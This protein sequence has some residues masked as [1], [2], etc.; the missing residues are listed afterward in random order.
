ML[1]TDPVA[2]DYILNKQA[3][4]YPK[5]K[6]IA[7]VLAGLGGPGILVA[8]GDVHKR[9]RFV[10]QKGFTSSNIRALYPFFQHHARHLRDR[11]QERIDLDSSVDGVVTDMYRPILRTTLDILGHAALGHS[12]HALDEKEVIGKV[13]YSE[14][15]RPPVSTNCL[16]RA[17][18]DL[19]RVAVQANKSYYN[20]AWDVAVMFFPC[21]LHLPF[22]IDAN[23]EKKRA[24]KVMD[25]EARKVVK[26][27]QEDR[28]ERND[29]LA[30]LLRANDNAKKRTVQA[31]ES[32]APPAGS[33]LLNK[34]TLSDEELL[35]QITN[36]Q[37]AGHETTGAQITW[38]IYYLATNPAVQVNLR[39]EIRNTREQLGLQ[40][41]SDPWNPDAVFGEEQEQEQ[42]RELTMEE[43]EGM[44]YLDWC[45]QEVCRLQPAVHTTSRSVTRDD[46][47][48]VDAT[49]SPNAPSHGIRVSPGQ[50]IMI[51]IEACNRDPLL[52]GA[53]ADTYRP[54]RWVK[55]EDTGK[56]QSTGF[57]GLTF[58]TGPRS[59]IGSRFAITEMKAVAIVLVNSIDFAHAGHTIKPQRWLTSR[60]FD[61]T[62]G[63]EQCTLRLR[64]AGV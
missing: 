48:P 28:D 11:L 5:Q 38:L 1:L 51:P 23:R 6:D 54:E 21:L 46:V 41:V 47:I 26:R 37:L 16:S 22:G 50:I 45:I 15:E 29:I 2:L 62:V 60:P 35:A 61:C 3:Y 30:C 52:W 64:R 53:D 33:R 32:K 10:M 63:T 31:M 42:G 7:R 36:L 12:F 55:A 24:R 59:C 39:E 44:Q 18:D 56:K 58:L 19:L 25:E 34:A 9:Q 13:S 57:G 27:G 43:V 49:R 17:F 20:L 14:D 8:E 4:H 40:S